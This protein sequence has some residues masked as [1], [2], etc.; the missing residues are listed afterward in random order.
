MRIQK[1]HLTFREIA[2]EWARETEEAK[3]PGRRCRD[4]IFQELVRA[5]GRCEFEDANARSCLTIRQLIGMRF[6]GKAL[7]KDGR[8]TDTPPRTSFNRRMLLDVL[9][10]MSPDSA[11]ELPAKADDVL[12]V[13][14]V[15]DYSEIYRQAYLERLTISKEDFG[16]WCDDHGQKR[17]AFWFGD[18]GQEPSPQP[19]EAEPA[20]TPHQGR[21]RRARDP[22]KRALDTLYPNGI[23]SNP[24][25]TL[26]AE[27][28]D[29]L[30]RK[31][32][33]PVSVDTVRR[34]ANRK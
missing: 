1:A 33:S 5:V 13:L 19:D 12:V 20:V 21:R 7:D 8:R 17:P 29:W 34:A 23:P 2:D 16:Q 9:T 6:N 10:A 22:A 18:H 3:A 27:V 32:E 30:T 25:K 11:L 15:G 26:T 24:W 14:D 31:G 28:N 4:E